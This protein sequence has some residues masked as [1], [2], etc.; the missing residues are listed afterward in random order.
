ML[1]RLPVDLRAFP[2]EQAMIPVVYRAN[3]R[4]PSSFFFAQAFPMRHKDV[5]YASNADAVE[6]S[7][8]LSFLQQ[9][10]ATASG[11]SRDVVIVQNPNNGL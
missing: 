4:D 11:V 6:I 7:K 8:F 10:T 1:E 3:F 9:L 5:I 2:A